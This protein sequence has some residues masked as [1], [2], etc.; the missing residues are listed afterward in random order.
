MI[1]TAYVLANLA[2]AQQYETANPPHIKKYVDRLRDR[3]YNYYIRWRTLT[4]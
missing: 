3:C 1:G 2:W 4:Q